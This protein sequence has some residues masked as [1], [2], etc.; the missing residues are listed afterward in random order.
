[1]DKVGNKHYSIKINCDD[2]L[3]LSPKN[4]AEEE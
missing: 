1:M 3:F 4:P 2:F